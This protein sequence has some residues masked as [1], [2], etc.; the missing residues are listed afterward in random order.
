MTGEALLEQLRSLD[1]R[2]SASGDRLLVDAPRGAL[3]EELRGTLLDR[4]AELLA[5]LAS[6]DKWARR[7]AGLLSAVAESDLRADLREL[8]EHRAAVC[9]FDGGLSRAE[10]ERIAFDE[11]RIAVDPSA[12]GT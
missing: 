2:L 3:N 9:E 6:A 10:A 11:L 4:K 7:A 12:Q 8:F 1:I 5:I